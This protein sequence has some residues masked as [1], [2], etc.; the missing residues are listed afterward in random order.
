MVLKIIIFFFPVLS[1][2][3]FFMHSFSFYFLSCHFPSG[4]VFLSSPSPAPQTRWPSWLTFTLSL[5]P[6]L[7]FIPLIAHWVGDFREHNMCLVKMLR[8]NCCQ[9]TFRSS[10]WETECLSRGRGRWRKSE[11]INQ[12]KMFRVA[13]T[14]KQ[15]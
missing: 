7:L 9:M 6:H 3:L 14:T 1:L 5:F 11:E 15:Q 10:S 8:C 13:M 4:F 12:R 2:I